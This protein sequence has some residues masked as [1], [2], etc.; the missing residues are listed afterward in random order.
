MLKKI[1]PKALATLFI[2]TYLM[3]A[4]PNTFKKPLVENKYMPK[5]VTASTEQQK[6]VRNKLFGIPDELLSEKK[7]EILKTYEDE[8][9]LKPTFFASMYLIHPIGQA[10]D[11]TFHGQKE[12]FIQ[13]ALNLPK[14]IRP[15][16]LNLPGLIIV[17]KNEK[18]EEIT[19]LTER[20]LGATITQYL[21]DQHFGKDYLKKATTEDSIRT[22][23]F[24][25][26]NP[27]SVIAFWQKTVKHSEKPWE[28][29]AKIIKANLKHLE[30]ILTEAGLKLLKVGVLKNDPL[31]GVVLNI[32]VEGKK[33]E[34]FIENYSPSK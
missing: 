5:T 12:R 9:F 6:D 3:G 13:D 11:F 26:S 29:T 30:P 19:Y 7:H 14:R 31:G 16:N 28:E 4:N 22:Y 15:F 17:P 23:K 25:A 8:I 21:L 18:D 2:S 34:K 32:E 10:P 33:L 20:M 1:G 24:F 27:A